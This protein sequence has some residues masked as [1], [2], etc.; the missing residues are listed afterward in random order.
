LICK[1]KKERKKNQ[2]KTKQNIIIKTRKALKFSVFSISCSFIFFFSI[3]KR[4]KRLE[5]TENV[6]CSGY[7]MPIIG[8]STTVYAYFDL[9][10]GSR[11]V[12]AK[13]SEKLNTLDF[14]A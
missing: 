7:Y 14:F 13:I 1:K 11:R 8:L 12:S 9:T 6:F 4:K 2:N 10:I 3:E 5:K